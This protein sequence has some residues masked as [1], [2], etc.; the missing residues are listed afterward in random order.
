MHVSSIND[1]PVTFLLDIAC[2]FQSIND[3]TYEA[4]RQSIVITVILS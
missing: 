1:E 2:L 3:R 4:L